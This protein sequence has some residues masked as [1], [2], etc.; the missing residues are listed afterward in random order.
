MDIT[1][2]HLRAGVDILLYRCLD[3]DKAP[4]TGGRL[5]YTGGAGSSTGFEWPDSLTITMGKV[6]V[7]ATANG[8]DNGQGQGGAG[9]GLVGITP[10]V[11]Q[12]P[13]AT[14]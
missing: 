2:N 6:G 9:P 11:V 4:G 3:G 7:A 1:W 10:G 12:D 13:G 14:S 5:V 8:T